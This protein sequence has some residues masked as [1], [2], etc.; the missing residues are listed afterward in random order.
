MISCWLLDFKVSYQ[1]LYVFSCD[2]VSP[3]D[4]WVSFIE[5]CLLILKQCPWSRLNV[6]L[7]DK[8]KT[9][10][11][12]INYDLSTQDDPYTS[13]TVL[14]T[15]KR[16]LSTVLLGHR[17]FFS[18]AIISLPDGI[19]FSFPF[20]CMLFS[21]LVLIFILSHQSVCYSAP[22]LCSQLSVVDA[23]GN[24]HDDS[25][26]EESAMD[27]RRSVLFGWLSLVLVFTLKM[28]E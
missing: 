21:S 4:K 16:F 17:L 19:S 14:A 23:T 2:V 5:L 15:H 20:P 9:H 22:V 27:P 7:V 11:N 13:R 12:S 24:V 6:P 18:I 1:Y 26:L 28:K 10:N 3:Q 8:K 25:L